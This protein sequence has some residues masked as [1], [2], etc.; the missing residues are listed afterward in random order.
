MLLP[1]APP[2][3]DEDEA[4]PGGPG[5]FDTVGI[6]EVP[7]LDD[8]GLPGDDPEGIPPE[9]EEPEL[10]EEAEPLDPDGVGID[11]IPPALDDEGIGGAP[12]G[13]GGEGID[14]IPPELGGEGIDGIP[15]EPGEG[16][17]GIDGIPDEPG[18]GGEGI[19]GIP[20]LV[21]A[22]VDDC[23]NGGGCCC[24]F[25]ICISQAASPVSAK[26]ASARRA[27]ETLVG[28]KSCL[29]IFMAILSTVLSQ[30]YST[31]SAISST[32]LS[33]ALSAT[34][35]TTALSTTAL[36]MLRVL[37]ESRSVT[38]YH[39]LRTVRATRYR[40]RRGG[41]ARTRQPRSSRHIRR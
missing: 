31:L 6:P 25:G 15:D 3:P 4:L 23:G 8:P 2:E 9:L 36:S 26:A 28:A 19:D 39:F 41:R 10:E 21:L 20:P 5:R 34:L 40:K 11:G 18:E 32:A 17:E 1:E 29:K 14:G 37:R 27:G 7:G 24:E 30:H 13:L 22:E 12:L 16:G 35:S 38:A 33:T